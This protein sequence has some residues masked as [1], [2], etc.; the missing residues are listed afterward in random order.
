VFDSRVTFTELLQFARN[1]SAAQG[2]LLDSYR[3]YLKTLARTHIHRELTV[4]ADA[5]DI[6]QETFLNACEQFRLFRGE[7]EQQL[8]A[9]LRTILAGR[10]SKL[11]RRYY[12]QKRLLQLEQ[13]FV[14]DL[15]NSS[16]A[17]ANVLADGG[18]TPSVQATRRELVVLVANAIEDLP[19]DYRS[20]ILL[21]HVEQLP[22]SDV[23]IRMGRSVDSVKKLWVR[24]LAQLQRDVEPL[25]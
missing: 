20:V 3:K 6:V 7:T 10:I 4:K 8:L 1:D 9:W 5:S 25:L 17:L 16:A 22:Y 14:G 12:S 11:S 21:R 18:S 2:L 24:A 23:A 15:D 13:R 19:E